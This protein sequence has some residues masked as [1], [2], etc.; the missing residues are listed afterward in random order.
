MG[1][2]KTA[3]QYGTKQIDPNGAPELIKFDFGY[4]P[5]SGSCTTGVV[6]EDIQA[7][8]R[9]DG[10]VDSILHVIGFTDV[11][12]NGLNLAANSI[13]FMGKIFILQMIAITQREL[14]AFSSKQPCSRAATATG[15]AGDQYALVC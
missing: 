5:I 1:N 7:D 3:T 15:G 4:C 8:L 14:G 6:V 10:G 13:D 12:L 11:C 2:G 9:S